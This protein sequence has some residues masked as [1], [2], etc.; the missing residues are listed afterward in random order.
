MTLK[1]QVRGEWFMG[2][3]KSEL[4]IPA[5]DSASQTL[6]ASLTSIWI[7]LH[8]FACFGVLMQASLLSPILL[9]SLVV[10]TLLFHVRYVAFSRPY[11]TDD[12]F[13]S[14]ALDTPCC[15]EKFSV[16][17]LASDRSGFQLR[18]TR[19]NTGTGFSSSSAVKF[20]TVAKSR[21]PRTILSQSDLA[22]RQ[23]W[24][25]T[26]KLRW[27][28][29]LLPARDRPLSGSVRIGPSK[30]GSVERLVAFPKIFRQVPRDVLV[31]PFRASGRDAFLVDILSITQEQFAFRVTGVGH[32]LQRVSWTDDLRI[33]WKAL[34][35]NPA[36]DDNV[37]Q[38]SLDSVS[39]LHGVNLPYGDLPH[40]PVQLPQATKGMA[41]KGHLAC[42]RLCLANP[43]CRAFSYHFHRSSA[44][45]GAKLRS[46]QSSSKQMKRRSVLEIED[47]VFSSLLEL[48][49]TLLSRSRAAGMC[50]TSQ[51]AFET[52]FGGKCYL[53]GSVSDGISGAWKERNGCAISAVL[54]DRNRHV[55]SGRTTYVVGGCDTTNLWATRTRQRRV[56]ESMSR[57]GGALSATTSCPAG[58]VMTGVHF[59]T[60]YCDG[61]VY[62]V[63]H[64]TFQTGLEL[65]N[66]PVPYAPTCP[67]AGKDLVSKSRPFC[68]LHYV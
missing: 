64:C 62:P 63:L 23:G 3:Q 11:L 34:P 52:S 20:K 45:T 26:L 65:E 31:Q 30:E 32:G 53:K 47:R 21:K 35:L 22:A 29:R 49:T 56:I 1:Y 54:D 37:K 38:I 57:L 18:V 36:D 50:S 9:N 66:D 2:P 24:T 55:M 7:V 25:Q 10:F 17:V 40:M 59:S 67:N 16:E 61:G 5:S 6:C 8:L 60:K 19:D 27:T 39:F 44:G 4:T 15:N 12:V 41:G 14:T 33:S 43:Q 68:C 51:T 58:S 28:V 42:A 46:K 48:R 13:V